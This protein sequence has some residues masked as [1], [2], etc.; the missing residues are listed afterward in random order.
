MSPAAPSTHRDP[1]TFAVAR[2]ILSTL[3]APSA[4]FVLASLA[5]FARSIVDAA[6][7]LRQCSGDAAD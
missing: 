3:D 7:L 6:A 4:V 5:T 2:A 1:D